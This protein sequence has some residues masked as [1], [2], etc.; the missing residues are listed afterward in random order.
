MEQLTLARALSGGKFLLDERAIGRTVLFCLRPYQMPVSLVLIT[1]L[2]DEF[3]LL[4]AVV[5]SADVT[6]PNL[7]RGK[8]ERALSALGICFSTT[9]CSCTLWFSRA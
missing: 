3:D 7:G 9:P 4:G 1:S 6:T 8:S 2:E 5:T